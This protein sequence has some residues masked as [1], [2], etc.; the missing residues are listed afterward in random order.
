MCEEI[1]VEQYLKIL[2]FSDV[3]QFCSRQC[4]VKNSVYLQI[5]E[6]Y[7]RAIKLRQKKNCEQTFSNT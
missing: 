3:M 6:V 2:G 4:I 5:A 1:E 7:K